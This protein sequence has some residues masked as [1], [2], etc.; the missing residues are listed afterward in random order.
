MRYALLVSARTKNTRGADCEWIRENER[1]RIAR[2]IHDDLGQRLLVLR[3]D[4]EPIPV[5]L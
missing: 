4:L 1:K 5:G 2:E 3:I